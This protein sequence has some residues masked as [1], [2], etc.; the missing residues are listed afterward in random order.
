[1]DAHA[2]PARTATTS[3]TDR[4]SLALRL[5]GVLIAAAGA[6]MVVAA[7]ATSASATR[8][9]F[10]AFFGAEI[11]VAGVL[12]MLPWSRASRG[13]SVLL[14]GLVLGGSLFYLGTA[15]PYMGR[16]S[17]T[18]GVIQFVA[19]LAALTLGGLLLAAPAAAAR[20]GRGEEADGAWAYAAREGLL[21]VVGTILLAIGTGQLARAG[22]MPP[23]WNWASFLGITVPG[24]LVLVVV[25]GAVKS[26]VRRTPPRSASRA[27][28]ILATEVL[29]VAGLSIML[30]GSFTNLNLGANGYEVG[31]KGN[32]AGLTLWIGAAAF[33]VV[34]R[35]AGKL[36][37]SDRGRGAPVALQALYVLGVLGVI[38]GERAVLMGKDPSLS[39]GG[40][41]P[42]AAAIAAAGFVVLVAGRGA[43]IA[44][45]RAAGAHELA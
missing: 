7:L 18:K 10:E 14:G 31:F 25:R 28:G 24:M 45:R 17:Y 13:R 22:L 43:V 11:L 8:R 23:K 12:A 29:L 21:L 40:A 32:D 9:A 39:F 30:Y 6:V 44:T 15:M 33:L 19:V 34:V 27:A 4:S 42:G 26:A 36:A 5:L 1:M 2:I 35:G 41:L 38:Y 37:A 20:R 3:A 16:A